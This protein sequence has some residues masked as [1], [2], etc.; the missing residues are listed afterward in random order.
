MR[1]DH[2][3]IGLPN[4]PLADS[5]IGYSVIL[6][7][8]LVDAVKAGGIKTFPAFTGFTKDGAVF[9]DGS[10]IGFDT[11]IFATGYRPAIQF[12]VNCFEMDADGYPIVNSYQ[13]TK[14]KDVYFVC[15]DKDY[16]HNIGWLPS[17]ERTAKAVVHQ[18]IPA[19]F[20]TKGKDLQ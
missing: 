1:A 3:S 12:A 17:L 2:G 13:S 19:N 20:K 5:Q 4:H 14:Y 9:A 8:K 6:G 18:I 10:E 11:I 15:P 7:N 16:E